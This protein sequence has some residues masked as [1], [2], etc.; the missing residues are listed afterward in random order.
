MAV[1]KD[2]NTVWLRKEKVL[3][4][5]L[6]GYFKMPRF[7]FYFALNKEIFPGDAFLVYLLLISLA[8]WD[9]RSGYFGVVPFSVSDI[10]SKFKVSPSSLRRKLKKLEEL[11]MIEKKDGLILINSYGLLFKDTEKLIKGKDAKTQKLIFAE[12][13]NGELQKMYEKYL[14]EIEKH[15]KMSVKRSELIHVEEDF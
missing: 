14:K 5:R 12:I 15:S 6:R 4:N 1:A 3:E 13:L 2:K 9:K 8:G 7:F 10:A 11:R